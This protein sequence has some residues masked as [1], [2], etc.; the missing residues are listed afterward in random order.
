MTRARRA[1]TSCVVAALALTFAGS[2][3]A[4]SKPARDPSDSPAVRADALFRE[5][6]AL[7]AKGDVALAC[8]KLADSY[9]LDPALGTL[10]NLAYCHQKQGRSYTAWSELVRAEQLAI[11]TEQQERASFAAEHRAELAA[12]LP[13]ARLVTASGTRITSLRID[14]QP[15]EAALDPTTPVVVPP[16]THE[17]TIETAEGKRAS[18]SATFPEGGSGAAVVV[19][20]ADD[21]TPPHEVA[22]PAPAATTPPAAEPSSGSNQRVIGYVVGGAGIVALGFGTFFGIATFSQK[23]AAAEGCTAAGCTPE[24]KRDGDRAYDYATL[25]TIF[26]V[27]GALATTAGVVLL[28]TTPPSTGASPTAKARA[29][30]FLAPGGGGVRGTF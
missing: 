25:S 11:R 28:L 14:G 17:L 4:Q 12:R 9:A 24:G 2:A 18:S 3:A 23:D 26:F 20:F 27:T 29:D 21:A 22:K 5:G 16:G 1:S 19:R 30:L 6:Q 10:L 8:A 15:Y 13:R 7:L